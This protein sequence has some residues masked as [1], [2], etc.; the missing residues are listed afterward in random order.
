MRIGSGGL[1]GV[2][3]RIDYLYLSLAVVL[4][5][6]G[7]GAGGVRV[8]EE[9]EGREVRLQCKAKSSTL[10]NNQQKHSGM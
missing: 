6:R 7:S 9:S 1:A 3:Q 4:P 10:E 8:E 5:P 2:V